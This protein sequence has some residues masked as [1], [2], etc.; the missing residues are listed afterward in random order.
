M[1]SSCNQSICNSCQSGYYLSNDKTQCIQKCVQDSNSCYNCTS[2]ITCTS[3]APENYL[4]NSGFCVP[5]LTSNC[6]ECKTSTQKCD[7]CYVGF[8]LYNNSLCVPACKTTGK[9]PNCAKCKGGSDKITCNQCLPGSYIDPSYNYCVACPIN[10]LTCTNAT[11]CQ[12]CSLSYYLSLDYQCLNCPVGCQNCTDFSVCASCSNG[13]TLINN[14]CIPNSCQ[15]TFNNC[16]ICESICTECDD[17]Y[18]LQNNT[19]VGNLSLYIKY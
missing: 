6:A 16:D 9:T 2:N 4:S 15:A 7:L 17:G 11:T 3:C 12:S 13:Y 19:C 14:S 1:C 8:T 5:C 10:C 18:I